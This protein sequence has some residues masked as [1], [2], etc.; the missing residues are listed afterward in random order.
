MSDQPDILGICVGNTRT[1]IGHFHD[2]RLIASKSVPSTDAEAVASTALA[3]ASDPG[4]TIAVLASVHEAAAGA[5]TAR[6]CGARG[7]ASVARPGAG[8]AIPVRHTLDDGTS[9]GPDRPR[10][11][12]GAFPQAKQACVGVEVGAAGRV[13]FIDGV[14]LFLCG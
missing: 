8:I 13:D 9:V 7:E 10:N 4:A 2:D 12:L 14:G 1:R 3:L 6:L 5:I 11:A